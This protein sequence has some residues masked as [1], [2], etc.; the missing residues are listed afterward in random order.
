MDNDVLNAAL[1]YA[2]RGW[3]V[4]PCRK[5]IPLTT[6]GVYD[7]T[8]DEA[9]IR[10]WWRKWSYA[11][12]AIAAGAS[13]LVIVDCD[14]GGEESLQKYAEARGFSLLDFP[15]VRTKS[16]GAHYYMRVYQQGLSPAVKI[17]PGV[18]IRAGASYAIAPPSR[19]AEG[20]WRWELPPFTVPDA[21]KAIVEL[22]E[23]A[24][25]VET[26]PIDDKALIKPGVRNQAL[27]A[28][29][30]ALRRY[31]AGRMTIEH[32][33]V[34]VARLACENVEPMIR[35]R[36]ITAIAKSVSRYTPKVR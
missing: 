26:P 19:D 17:L 6:R 9:T 28:V 34:V 36:E 24:P 20:V 10:A 33:L 3:A 30:G 25:R 13:R 23:K 5:K 16:G 14:E 7:A 18:D 11:N 1:E 32:V 8:T 31:G 12:V 22:L 2:R 29:A 27:T 35:S 4:L 21:P 15:R